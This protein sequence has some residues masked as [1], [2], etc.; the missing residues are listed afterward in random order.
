LAL[1]LW[2]W[3]RCSAASASLPDSG[4]STAALPSQGAYD[5]LALTD[6][7]APSGLDL[8][9]HDPRHR[10]ELPIR[11]YLP[12]AASSVNA[13][14]PAPVILFSPGLG[15][16]RDG[17]RF[18]AQ[19]WAARGYVAVVLQHPGSDDTVWRTAPEGEV[20]QALKQAA[21]AENYIARAR[22]VSAVLNQLEAWNRAP[23]NPLTGRLDR[24]RVGMAGHSFG[25][26]TTE[27]VSGESMAGR[28]AVLTDRR[29]KAAIAMSPSPPRR[30]DPASAFGSVKIPWMLMTGTEDASPLGEESAASR[31]GVYP[32]LTRAPKY[33]LVLDKAEHSAFSDRELPSDR[34]ERDPRYHRVILAL[35]TAFWDE[36]LR[37][38]P[39]AAAWLNGSG[40]RTVMVPADRW[41]FAAAK[42]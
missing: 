4:P 9:V 10:R 25:A 23:G 26:L 12:R 3:P 17:Y 33:Q 32:Y 28:G 19:H 8:T 1:G 34:H 15:G 21:N 35:S 36:Y 38:D 5:P 24:A 11:V 16:A 22:D 7:H 6:P 20:M 18:L 41:E 29:I 42:K 31:L 30:G 2:A 13:A 14:R 40:P 27:A 39:A 37:G